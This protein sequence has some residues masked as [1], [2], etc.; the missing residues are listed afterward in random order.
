H[1]KGTGLHCLSIER[2]LIKKFHLKDAFIIPTPTDNYAT[3]LGK[4]AAQYLETQLQQGDLLGIG[5]GETISK[6][7]ENIH[8]ESSINLSIVTLTGGVN[9]YLPRKQNYLHYMHGDLHIIPTPFLASTTEM[10]Q[11]I[12]SEPSV[13]DMLHVASLAHT[14]VVGIGGLSQDAT[15]VKEEKLTLREMTYI[16]SQNGAGDI[17]G[18]FYDTNGDLL[19]LSHHNRLIGT[20]LSVLRNMKH[21]VGVAGGIEKIDAIYGALKG[22]FIHT[23]ITDEETALSLLRKDGD[24]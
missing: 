16:R 4:A 5:W 24:C 23:L 14:A 11:S 21:V 8:F 6:M 22:K 10:A 18:Q 9:H 7:L 19:E 17:L 3:S 1:V 13:K 15:I 20:P 2:D 12:L